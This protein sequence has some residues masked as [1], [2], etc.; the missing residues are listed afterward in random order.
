MEQVFDFENARR[1]ALKTVNMA[2]QPPTAVTAFKKEIEML[3]KLQFSDRV[4]K[5]V[6]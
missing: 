2:D 1:L 4:I 3:E 5:L 6:D